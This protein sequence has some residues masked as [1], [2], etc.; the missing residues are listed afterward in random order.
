M[1]RYVAIIKTTTASRVL[2][3]RYTF[4]KAWISTPLPAM[5]GALLPAMNLVS[6]N[7]STP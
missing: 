6:G 5:L 4:H 3:A 2:L 1:A 7:K